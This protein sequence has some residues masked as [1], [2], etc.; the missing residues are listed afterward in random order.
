M[1]H[2]Y[3]ELY[4]I[5]AA[6]RL[7]EAKADTGDLHISSN[8]AL[9]SDLLPHTVWNSFWKRN[10][11]GYVDPT[12]VLGSFIRM[13]QQ[14]PQAGRAPERPFMHLTSMCVLISSF[15]RAVHC[16]RLKFGYEYDSIVK[17]SDPNITIIKARS[18]QLDMVVSLAVEKHMGQQ[19]ARPSSRCS[20]A[21]CRNFP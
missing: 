18:K 10:R 15:F 2:L 9:I 16:V 12:E 3:I 19:N 7:L 8:S 20:Y 13:A 6:T 1:R 11:G 17:V 21:R 14:T 4:G 5:E